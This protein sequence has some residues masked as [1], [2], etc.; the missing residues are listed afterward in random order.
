M[1]YGTPPL[2]GLNAR[3]VAKYSSL[4]LS[5]A[6]SRKRCKIGSKL[7]LITN[8]KS[9]VS[10][11]LVPKSVTLNGVM[12]VILRYF[13]ELMYD[14]VVKQLLQFQNLPLIIYDHIKT[15]CTIIQRLFGQNRLITRFDGRRCIDN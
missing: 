5:K 2:E 7:V 11:R 10:F 15:V 8:R 12:A 4:D 3:G 14:V 6:I 13:S 1:M 9:Y